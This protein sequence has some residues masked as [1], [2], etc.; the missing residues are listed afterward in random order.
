MTRG[1]FEGRW[2]T[3]SGPGTAAPALAVLAVLLLGASG[4]AAAIAAAVTGMLLIGAGVAVLAVAALVTLLVLRRRRGD[5]VMLS[6]ADGEAF[7]ERAAAL[8]ESARPQA[9]ASQ[10][11]VIVNNYFGGTHVHALPGTGT[12]IMHPAVPALE[13]DGEK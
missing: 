7:A 4:A 6:R 11:P 9:A 5:L 12:G 2:W 13:P 1:G 3:D 8:R 10:V